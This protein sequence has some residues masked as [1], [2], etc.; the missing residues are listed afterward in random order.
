[1]EDSQGAEGAHR[2]Q[3]GLVVVGPGGQARASEAE[4]AGRDHYGERG[5]QPP[6]GCG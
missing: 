1:M 5:P 3:T 2:G 4:G 6:A